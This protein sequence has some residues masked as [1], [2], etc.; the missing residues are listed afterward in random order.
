MSAALLVIDLQRAFCAVDG[1]MAKQG[2]DIAPLAR[3]A[4]A[5]RGLVDAARRAR[6]PVIW[7][8]IGWAADYSDGGLLTSTLRPNLARIG[9][10]KRDTADWALLP[11]LPVEGTDVIVDKTRFSALVDTGLETHLRTIGITRIA[12]A[13]VTT[14]MCVE[15]TV[16][17]LGQRDFEVTVVTDACADFSSAVHDHAV[18]RMGFGFARLSTIAAI[19]SAWA[20]AR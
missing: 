6:I 14:S 4:D 3:A 13:G 19:T 10:L 15:S 2:W 16:R 5:A 17:D 12:V 11:S 9:A 7:T 18:E 20:D 8:R 1:S